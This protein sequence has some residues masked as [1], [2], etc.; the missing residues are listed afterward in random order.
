MTGA[1]TQARREQSV[2]MKL[3]N[4]KRG[5]VAHHCSAAVSAMN[6]DGGTPLRVSAGR[7]ERQKTVL[8]RCT[9]KG[10]EGRKQ[11]FVAA[12]TIA[13]EAERCGHS[14]WRGEPDTTADGVPFVREW[15]V[16]GD[17][18][19]VAGLF[20][21]LQGQATGVR[22]EFRRVG[23]LTALGRHADALEVEYLLNGRVTRAM[24]ATVGEE[25]ELKAKDAARRK[26]AAK[27]ALAE[28]A[29]CDAE[30]LAATVAKVEAFMATVPATVAQLRLVAIHKPEWLAATVAA[31]SEG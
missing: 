25:A 7:A 22:H 14:V 2:R 18:S 5:R 12:K 4:A 27:Q 16:T 10:R 6:A 1:E 19:T 30:R 28:H 15:E 21:A 9:A 17:E 24:G 23:G 29:E 11:S 3:R 20:R 8:V 31:F 13:A 26:A